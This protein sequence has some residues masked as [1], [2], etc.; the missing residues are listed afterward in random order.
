M[1]KLTRRQRRHQ[2]GGETG[3]LGA[4]DV[5]EQLVTEHRHALA[6]QLAE[7]PQPRLNAW[8]KGLP[9]MATAGTPAL[10]ATA[11]T[12]SLSPFERIA[13]LTPAAS[14]LPNQA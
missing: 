6:R 12:L 10:A 2:D 8:A 14:R 11:A 4:E 3:T 13:T 5:G 7:E 1:R 9:A